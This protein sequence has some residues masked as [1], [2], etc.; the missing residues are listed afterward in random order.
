MKMFKN[1][2]RIIIVGLIVCLMVSLSLNFF[3]YSQQSKHTKDHY[4]HGKYSEMLYWQYEHKIITISE[5]IIDQLDI[6]LSQK[7]IRWNDLLHLRNSFQELTNLQ[8][9]Y[10][11]II[12]HDLIFGRHVIEHIVDEKSLFEIDQIDNLH[13]Y[14]FYDRMISNIGKMITEDFY[15]ETVELNEHVLKRFEIAK[16]MSTIHRSIYTQYI[17]SGFDY[18]LLEEAMLTRL[19][20]NQ[21]MISALPELA[22]LSQ[23]LITTD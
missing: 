7:S 2:S 19:E 23:Q 22:R 16:E 3:N 15:Q 10:V 5:G 13:G 11:S 1:P 9:N 6:V 21:E 18:A 17:S 4:F 14:Y 8:V 20:L 12:Q